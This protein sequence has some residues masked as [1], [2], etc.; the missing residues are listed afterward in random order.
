MTDPIRTAL[1][2][3]GR[4]AVPVETLGDADD[5]YQAG[6]SSH[7]SVNL[8]LALEEAFNVEFPDRLLKRA[9]FQTIANLRAAVGELTSAAA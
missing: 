1:Q 2:Q 8:M 6:L 7:A 3:F 5:L 9:T 4:L